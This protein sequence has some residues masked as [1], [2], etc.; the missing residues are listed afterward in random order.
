MLQSSINEES[1]IPDK[2]DEEE[3]N[4]DEVKITAGK[5]IM[6]PFINSLEN[7]DEHLMQNQDGSV[8]FQRS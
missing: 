2:A 3:I 7:N 6:N 5:I 8:R 1:Q 4:F